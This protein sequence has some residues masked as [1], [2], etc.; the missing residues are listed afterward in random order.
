MSLYVLSIKHIRGS[1]IL[2]YKHIF[3]LNIDTNEEAVFLILMLIGYTSS[4]IYS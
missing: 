4:R 1:A 3:A 2:I